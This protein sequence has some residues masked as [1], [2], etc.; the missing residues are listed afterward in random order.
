M[1][2]KE[3]SAYI[4]APNLDYEPDKAIRLGHIWRN[5]R[6][7]GSFCGQPLAIPREMET[8]HTYK[9]PWFIGKGHSTCGS[10]GVWAK[11]LQVV[12][13]TAQANFNWNNADDMAHTFER[14]DTYSIEPTPEYLKASI[15]TVAGDAI[16]KGE[17]LYM[18]TGVKVARGA[19]G[20]IFS[21]R[22]V[23]VR[24]RVGASGASQGVDAEGRPYLDAS[25]NEYSGVSY[26]E[27]SDFVFAYRVREILYRKRDYKTRVGDAMYGGAE[28]P[29]GIDLGARAEASVVG[30][31]SAE[32]ES[33][34][35]GFD[36]GFSDE[37]MLF[38]ND[39][40]EEC[41]FLA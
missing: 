27:S 4:R 7:P 37:A 17:R 40:G 39:D 6:D 5:P 24:G 16:K 22:T 31:D 20:T 32:L 1:G 21:S 18:I 36:D 26:G 9:A 10:V 28:A 14:L 34:D 33:V 38:I 23:G 41:L 8:N 11:F 13:V 35:V 15:E 25:R 29:L 2:N 12:G 30:V 19:V 3:L